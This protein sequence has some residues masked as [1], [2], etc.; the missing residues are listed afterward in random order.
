MFV[1]LLVGLVCAPD[2]PPKP[3]S[4][5]DY[6]L[7]KWSSGGVI[8]YAKNYNFDEDG[9]KTILTLNKGG[10]IKVKDI[11]YN[12]DVEEKN[13]FVLDKKG[14]LIEGTMF[15][16]PK[17]GGTYRL[18][19]FD[20]PLSAGTKVSYEKDKIVLKI[21]E[22]V[23]VSEPEVVENYEGEKGVLS[24]QSEKG[25]KFSEEDIQGRDGKIKEINYDKNGFYVSEDIS[26]KTD[27]GKDDFLV[28][29]PKDG[30]TY[31]IF[32]ETK[33]N[34]E[35]NSVFIEEDKVILT[36]FNGKGAS[37]FF[38]ENNRLGMKITP[39]NTVSVQAVKGMVV[40]E[41]TTDGEL[42]K[43]ANVKINGESIANLDKRVFYA[44]GDEL[45]FNPEG[46]LIE[47]FEHG[48]NDA[49]VKLS[50]I[51]NKGDGLKGFDVYSNGKDQYASAAPNQFE[52]ELE[53]Y[54][55]TGNFYVSST[56]A[57]NQLT[58]E[59]QG[60]YADLDAETQGKILDYA[61]GQIGV[62]GASGA[63][64][65]AE[66]SASLQVI[67]NE[68]IA[69]EIRKRQNPLKAVVRIP[70]GGGSGTIVGIDKEGYP[71]VLTAGHLGG[72]TSPGYQE[73]IQLPDGREFTA[74]VIAGVGN[75]PNGDD[76][77]LMRINEK[78]SDIPFV[79][80]ASEKYQL[81]TGDIGLRAGCPGC[82]DFKF[83]KTQI[84][85]LGKTIGVTDYIYGG[86]S[87]GGLSVN[88]RIF[89]VVSTDGFYTGPDVI[90]NFMRNQGY[91]YLIKIS[92]S[93]VRGWVFV[94]VVV[95]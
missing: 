49:A 74:T 84:G 4:G 5:D 94:G 86:E 30:K 41:K 77:S 50:L 36:N 54:K 63:K 87:G 3:E 43:L 71:I 1:L 18:K 2:N 12:V 20:V 40:V 92:L 46:S 61:G 62:A 8:A 33:I 21:P 24:Y 79:P 82:E 48:E 10:G 52:S 42:S 19:G 56:V 31:L 39:E 47:G 81:K 22:G 75:Y 80:V 34:K 13:K 29:V 58:P 32:D 90:R 91:D 85:S 59:A 66:G 83:T 53:F 68:L 28:N 16:V 38:T 95:G 73:R 23:E 93:V 89:G 11:E 51:D 55:T 35:L 72:A 57:F 88:G 70:T 14:N 6:E 69:E 27:D 60:F 64:G 65:G 17:E 67:L 7:I 15:S 44:G 37:V 78:V 25:V 26:V 9:D 76:V 45:Y